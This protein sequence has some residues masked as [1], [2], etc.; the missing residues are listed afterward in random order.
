MSQEVQDSSA[1]AKHDLK[2]TGNPYNRFSEGLDHPEVDEAE[3]ER[4]KKNKAAAMVS[5][6]LGMMEKTHKRIMVFVDRPTVLAPP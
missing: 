2:D 5:I 6:V 3:G 1:N 4:R